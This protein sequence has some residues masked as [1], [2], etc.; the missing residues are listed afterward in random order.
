VRGSAAYRRDAVLALVR[1]L[2]GGLAT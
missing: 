1:R 2:L